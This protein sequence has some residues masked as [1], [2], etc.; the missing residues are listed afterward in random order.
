MLRSVGPDTTPSPGFEERLLERVLAN[1]QAQQRA[2]RQNEV[3]SRKRTWVIRIAPAVA[4]AVLIAISGWWLL[5]GSIAEASADFAEMLERIRQAST[6]AFDSCFSI[7]GEPETKVQVLMAFPG[8]SRVTWPDGRIHIIDATN[9]KMLALGP[10]TKKAT[11]WNSS[12]ETTYG[13]PLEQLR[14][15]GKSDGR[16]VGKE[17]WNNQEIV[18]YQV[19]CT[20][21]SMRVWVDPREELPVR[22]ESRLSRDSQQ[23]I[24]VMD[25][26][27]WNLSISDSLFS[28]TAP[29]GYVLE[30]PEIKPSEESLIE[31]L[32]ACAQM[33]N[34]SFPANLDAVAV[35]DLVLKSHPEQVYHRTVNAE[36][37][38]ATDMD[39]QTKETYRTCLCGLAFIKRISEN[40]SWRYAGGDVKPGDETAIVC[41][42]K[43][44]GSATYRAVY[45]D[46]K[47]RDVAADSFPLQ[48]HSGHKYKDD[49]PNNEM[50]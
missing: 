49:I 43:L 46:L 35:L 2:T 30:R 12:V 8:R 37:K 38:T 28:L 32:R 22:I 31:L 1:A 36:D 39:N 48:D 26:F 21:G 41:W 42:W 16:F 14:R 13:E 15:A 9:G 25:N 23:A 24:V 7:P 40:G 33:S 3:R 18:V 50:K 27:R 6:V 29:A 4:A 10:L 47:V 44:P 5:V 19:D 45:G 17:T 11:L 34:G 20:Q